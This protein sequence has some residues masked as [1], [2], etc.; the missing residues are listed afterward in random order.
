MTVVSPV[1]PLLLVHTLIW[2]LVHTATPLVMATT[3]SL[4]DSSPQS[5]SAQHFRLST[6]H[7]KLSEDMHYLEKRLTKIEKH[8]RTHNG[9]METYDDMACSQ[10]LLQAWASGRFTKDNIAL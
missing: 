1:V 7:L 5:Q 8:L 4:V 6:C 2:M 3:E 9:E 10:D